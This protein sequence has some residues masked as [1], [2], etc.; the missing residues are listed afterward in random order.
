[1]QASLQQATDQ[2]HQFVE[3]SNLNRMVDF[4]RRLSGPPD[5]PGGH[6]ITTDFIITLSQEQAHR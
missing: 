1:V 3:T 2:A 6:P 5:G 4:K